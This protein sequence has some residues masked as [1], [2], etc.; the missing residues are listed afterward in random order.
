[1]KGWEYSWLGGT[2]AAAADGIIRGLQVQ[3]D[4]PRSS[5][6]FPKEW[7][8]HAADVVW[9]LDFPSQGR[10]SLLGPQH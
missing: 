8:E 6:L 9:K 7:W 5:L 1:M 3:A 4:S 10:L 2:N